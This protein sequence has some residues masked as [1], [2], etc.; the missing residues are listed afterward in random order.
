MGAPNHNDPAMGARLSEE[1]LRLGITNAEIAT[2]I[3]CHPPKVSD[4]A[5][6]RSI[7]YSWYLA[8]LYEL[9]CDVIYILVGERTRWQ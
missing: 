8:R 6:G 3:G 2:R 1:I 7:P 4:W 9:G 5:C